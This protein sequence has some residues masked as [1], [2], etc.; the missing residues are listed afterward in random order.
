MSDDK[1]P[2]IRKRGPALIGDLCPYCATDYEEG[3]PENGLCQSAECPG[4]LPLLHQCAVCHS[5]WDQLDLNLM[6]HIS[7]PARET[8][9]ASGECPRDACRGTCFAYE[10]EW[11]D[12]VTHCPLCGGDGPLEL[13]GFTATCHGVRV[14]PGGWALTDGHI[15][16][17]DEVFFCTK[18]RGQVPTEWVFYK[19][20]RKEAIEK[21]KFGEENE[22]AEV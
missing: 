20:T 21:M 8:G 1:Q 17:S 5:F 7:A 10:G 6:T 12:Y 22:H 18:C 11:D 19:L 13:A 16:T 9:E 15:D 4:A 14:S 3:P 2:K